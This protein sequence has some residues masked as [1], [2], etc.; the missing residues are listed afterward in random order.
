MNS[1]FFILI[2][3]SSKVYSQENF[4]VSAIEN[5]PT[6]QIKFITDSKSV[7]TTIELPSGKKIYDTELKNILIKSGDNFHN[8]AVLPIESLNT[9]KR[10]GGDGTGGGITLGNTIKNLISKESV[11]KKVGGDGT[12]GG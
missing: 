7:I 12:G 3:I 4:K 8:I 5:I 10:V 2:L 9:F 6:D 11:I 1:I